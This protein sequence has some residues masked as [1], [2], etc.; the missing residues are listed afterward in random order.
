MRT[1]FFKAGLVKQGPNTGKWS[2]PDFDPNNRNTVFF[3]SEET[4]NK[5]IADR[6]IKTSRYEKSRKI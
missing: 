2:V 1:G 5:A 3:E 4:A 6:K